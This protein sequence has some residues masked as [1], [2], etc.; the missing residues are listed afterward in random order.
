[1][2]PSCVAGIWSQCGAH[3]CTLH[4]HSL[5]T[6]KVHNNTDTPPAHKQNKQSIMQANDLLLQTGSQTVTGQGGQHQHNVNGHQHW[7]DLLPRSSSNSHKHIR[8]RRTCR[9]QDKPVPPPLCL[10]LKLM[11]RVSGKEGHTRDT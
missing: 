1:M 9:G 11:H 2:A 4:T 6:W 8:K 10:V 3:N 7:S 5:E